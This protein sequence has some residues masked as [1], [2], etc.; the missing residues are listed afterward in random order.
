MQD[1]QALHGKVALVVGATTGIGEAVACS[2]AKSGATVAL[3]GRR[4]EQLDR[5]VAGIVDGGGR[6]V[7]FRCD[8]G[9]EQDVL[10]MF[11]AM[12]RDP[13]PIDILVNNAGVGYQS[14]IASFATDDFRQALDV[15]VLGTAICIREAMKQLAHRPGTAIV[16]ISSMAAHRVPTGGF[17]L[18]AA[19]KHALRAIMESLRTELIEVGSATKV[20]SISPGTVA[21]DFHRLF[22]RSDQDP[23]A[24]LPFERL[25]AQD[26]ADAVLYVLNAPA[27]VQINDILIRPI[28]QQG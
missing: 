26:I 2:L 4:Q 22:A 8:I 7:P 1:D 15:N 11:A 23:T 12:A 21:T 18:Y 3:A 17:G 25:S 24:S 10:A 20:A 27:H 5:V 16:T 6:A 19:T 13:G 9:K 14:G 28:G